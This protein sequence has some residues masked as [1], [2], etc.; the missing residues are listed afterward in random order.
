MQ[1][2]PKSSYLSIFQLPRMALTYQVCIVVLII[3]IHEHSEVAMVIIIMHVIPN[4]PDVYAWIQN[5]FLLGGWGAYVARQYNNR[6]HASLD[7]SCE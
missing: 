6:S 3:A 1:E 4:Y 2:N 7:N 5:F